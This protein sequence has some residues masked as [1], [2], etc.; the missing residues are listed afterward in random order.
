M[1]VPFNRPGVVGN[2][3]AYVRDAIE[4]GHISGAGSY[5]RRCEA[6]LERELGAHRVLLT[7]SCTHSL[8]M[9]ALLLR[10]TPGDEVIVPSFTFPSSANAFVL[11]GATPVFVDVREDTLNLDERLLLQ[12]ITS[13]TR[14]VVVVHYGGVAAELESI[15]ALCTARGIAVVEDN[16]HGLFGNYH[17]QPLG[18]LGALG[19]L[20]FHETKN[21][22]CGEGGALV[23]ND[24]DLVARAEILREKGTDRSRFFRGEVD[25]YQWVDVGSSYVPSDMLAA[26]LLGQLEQRRA[27]QESRARLWNRYRG[28][29]DDW[30]RRKGARLPEVPQGVTSSHHLFHVLLAS[31]EE[32]DAFI[33]HLRDRGVHAIFHYQPLHLSPMGRRFGGRDGQCPVTESAS[34]RVVRLPLFASLSDEEQSIVIDAVL[35]F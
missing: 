35:A 32:R 33:R 24:E 25:R 19:A 1:V 6:L 12:A 27:V 11:H 16:A 8:E 21:V 9:A 22:Y 13:R 29:L 31:P 20:S 15:L 3:L 4:R 7:T 26:F 17:D 14:A 18:T 10:I 5:T 23:I 2:E 34:A 28:E 30:A